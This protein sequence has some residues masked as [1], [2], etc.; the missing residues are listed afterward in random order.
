MGKYVPRWKRTRRFTF[1]PRYAYATPPQ[2][3]VCRECGFILE[4]KGE[5]EGK[6]CPEIEV[7]PNCGAKYSFWRLK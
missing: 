6:H 4:M 1:D 5:Y 7:C 3:C 2:A